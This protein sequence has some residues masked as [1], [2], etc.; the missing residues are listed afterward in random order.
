MGKEE[1]VEIMLAEGP[2]VRECGC[3]DIE[4]RGTRGKFVKSEGCEKCK[5][6]GIVYD[7]RYIEACR[8]LGKELPTPP[9]KTWGEL[10]ADIEKRGLTLDES[11]TTLV[12][13]LI[14]SA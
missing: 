11:I 10:M 6:W 1:A 8:V 7:E 2:Y 9:K 3:K 12:T 5:D 4:T 13:T 14:D